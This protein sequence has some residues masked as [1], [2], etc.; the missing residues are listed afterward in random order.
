MNDKVNLE[1]QKSELNQI[2][3]S[4]LFASSVSVGADWKEDACNKMFEIAKKIKN[5]LGSDL[6]LEHVNF[7]KEEYYE[8]SW[9]E[10]ILN[11]FGDQLEIISFENI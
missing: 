9:S 4:L 5:V 8:D 10:N 7:F 3:E 2:V 11:E 1:L 6:K